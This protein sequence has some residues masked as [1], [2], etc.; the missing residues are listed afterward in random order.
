MA[1]A[2]AMPRLLDRAGLRLQDFELYEIHEAFAAQVLCTLAPGRTPCSAASASAPRRAARRDRPPTP[3]RQRRL[4]RRGTSLRRDRRPDR[5]GPRQ[6][7]VRRGGGRGIITSAPPR[8]REP[9]RSCRHPGR[10]LSDRYMQLVGSRPGACS[11]D[12]SGC[13]G[14]S[15][16]P[17]T[18]PARRS[19]RRRVLLGETPNGRLIGAAATVMA[20]AGVRLAAGGEAPL[21]ALI[22][23]VGTEVDILDPD[24][25]GEPLGALVLD[26]SGI[27]DCDE[28]A[29]LH[30]FFHPTLG[31][32]APC[33]R[34]I[35]LATAPA[36][37]ED[38][39]SPTAQRALEG[40]TRSL[41][42]EFGRGSTVQL[43][44]V[45]TG[46]ARDGVDA[47]VP[48]LPAL[49]LRVRSGDPPGPRRATAEHRLAEAVR[50]QARADHRRLAWD[51][52]R[53]RAAA[54]RRRRPR[55]RPRRP[56]AGRRAEGGHRPAGR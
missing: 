35:V 43:V 7:P 26:A 45:A 27:A 51:R 8:A 34:V 41:G 13:H 4:A 9:S 55:P 21:R 40:F 44:Q 39:R 53:D 36:D 5:R 50:R 12:V 14:P 25:P 24:R 28:L 31:L 2:F 10:P 37:C 33:G 46:P 30:A 20:E 52:R 19:I 3:E 17:A 29:L 22:A 42:K 56:R 32:L 15:G 11:Q 54:G 6:G 1:P 23:A 16:S 18:C 47:S 49:G 38:A 48:A